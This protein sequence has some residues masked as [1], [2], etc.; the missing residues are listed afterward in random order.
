MV[1]QCSG[2]RTKIKLLRG[3]KRIALNIC[4]NR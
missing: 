2:K 3:S 4:T 1:T